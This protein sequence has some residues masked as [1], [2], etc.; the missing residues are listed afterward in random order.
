MAKMAM[1]NDPMQRKARYDERQGADIRTGLD[2]K[3]IYRR[4]GMKGKSNLLGHPETT[5]DLTFYKQKRNY[6][7]RTGEFL[8]TGEYKPDN[9]EVNSGTSIFDP[10]LCEICYRWFCVSGGTI[11]DPFAG[12]SVRGIVA[13]YLGYSY[14][15]VDLRAEQIAANREQAGAILGGRE[16]TPA[17]VVGNSRN[18]DKHCADVRADLIF[19]CPPYFDLEVYSD[20]PEDL[21]TLEW[22]EFQTQYAEIITK[23][24]A[25]LNDNSFAVFVVGDVR[26]KKGYYRKFPAFTVEC[27]ERAGMMLYNDIVLVNV[28]GSLPLRV[29][30]QFSGG[31][32]V[33]KM[34]QN[35][36]V[37]YKGDT[38]SIKG[39]FGEIETAEFELTNASE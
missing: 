29:G 38:K 31:R 16:I 23:A 22:A 30:K 18:I 2:E 3:R 25:L 34:H 11:I 4:G 28:A 36:L 1:A 39:K 9:S 32:K 7:K 24:V 13:A 5:G 6:E 14:I 8:S 37:F 26:D 15:G 27:F 35:V 20:D 10:V 12:G 19:S 21:S 17:W 33:G